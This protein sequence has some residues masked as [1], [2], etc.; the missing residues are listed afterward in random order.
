[1]TKHQ[2]EKHVVKKKQGHMV[3]LSINNITM[4][5]NSFTKWQKFRFAQIESICR[6][7]NKSDQKY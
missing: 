2:I 6:R 4:K 5:F 3:K 1:M 7:Q